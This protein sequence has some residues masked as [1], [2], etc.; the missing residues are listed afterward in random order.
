[1]AKTKKIILFIVEGITD[2]IS[3]GLILS[4]LVSTHKEDVKFKIING[5]LTTKEGIN[6][7]NILSKITE[8]IKE[9]LGQDIYKKSDI[10]KVVHLVDTDGAYISEDCLIHDPEIETYIY[11]DE[12]IIVSNIKKAKNRNIQKSQ[13]LDK[14]VA[15]GTVYVDLQYEVYYFS[16]N[17]E[18]VLHNHSNAT[19]EEKISYAKSF[20]KQYSDDLDGF[21]TLINDEQIAVNGTYRETWIYI[22]QKNNSLQRNCNFHLL[23]NEII[24]Q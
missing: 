10:I 22:K 6:P 19:E 13:I 5:D 9:F 1:L 7:Q 24:E 14:L 16:S 21:I 4:R 18:H 2:E 12:S 15:T 20:E 11:T 23:I 3:L 17:I 8:Q